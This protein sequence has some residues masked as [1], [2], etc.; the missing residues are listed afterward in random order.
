M[1][2]GYWVIR[3]YEAG[4]VGEKTKFWI[5]GAR[6]SSRNR[7]KE[8]STIKKQEQNEYSAQ[9]QMARLINANFHA[10]D[11]LLG[12]DYSPAGMDRLEASVADHPHDI[13]ESGDAEAD[14]MQQLRY[15]ADREMRLCLRR[16][17]REL[18]KDGAALKYIAITSDMDGDTGEAVR[19]HH[20]L[21]INEEARDAFVKKWAELGGVNWSPLS[22]QKDFTPIA[23]YLLRQV[24]RVPDEKKYVTSRNLVRPQPKDRA[25]FSDAEVR[26]PRG[27]KLLFRNEFRPGKP[28]YI[29]YVLPERKIE[30]PPKEEKIA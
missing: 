28:Q 18:Q 23:E 10:G 12:L 4:A 25:V 6:P 5:Q 2:D 27:G 17:K 7:R 22:H 8:Q 9:K 30:G 15:A 19:V 21:V 16:V 26:V 20:H 11:L 29:R 13:T 14:H 1:K 24:R 3:T